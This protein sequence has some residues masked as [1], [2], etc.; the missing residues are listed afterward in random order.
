M[1]DGTALSQNT[2]DNSK[3]SKRFTFTL[4]NFTDAEYKSLEDAFHLKKVSYVLFA[5]EVGSQGTPHL[6]GY[7]EVTK[8]KTFNGIRKALEIPRLA[9]MVAKGNAKENLAYC[10][11]ENSPLVFGAPM[12]QGERTDIALVKDLIDQGKSM[13]EVANT[14]FKT[15]VRF[16]RSLEGYRTMV[17]NKTTYEKP[18]VVCNLGKTGTGKSRFVYDNHEIESIWSWTDKHWFDNYELHEVALFDDFDG[19]DF[20]FRF[21]L[22]VLD[23]YPIQ[24]PV[25][26]GF[27]AWRPKVIYFTTNVHPKHWF[28]AQKLEDVEGLLRRFDLIKEFN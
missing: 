6:Q 21:L 17:Q 18:K 24:V 13:I 15:Y 9:L 2:E 1:T 11:K 3:Q 27:V 28:P 8:K 14:D 22:R 4:N 20:S 23:R 10:S 25:K 19:S 16:K 12:I 7:L 5:K 26:G